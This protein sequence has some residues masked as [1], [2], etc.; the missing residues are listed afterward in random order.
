MSYTLQHTAE[1]IDYKLNLIDKNKNWLPYPYE[2]TPALPTGLEDVGDGSILT[3]ANTT[4]VQRI[5]LNT[6]SLPAGKYTV[7]LDITDIT[8][9][10]VTN[11]AFSLEVTGTAVSKTTN[12]SGI[13]TLNLDTTTAVEVYLN[14]PSRFDTDL[15]IKPQIEEGETKTTWVPYMDKIG[16][17][18]DERFNSTS[19]KLKNVLAFMKLV[20]IED[21]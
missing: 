5:L 19:T 17:Y 8:E 1:A 20:E 21:T 7:S 15:L 18:V 4:T 13:V 2:Y 6:C 11:S 12:S 16:K 3:S 9:I 10:P 14:I